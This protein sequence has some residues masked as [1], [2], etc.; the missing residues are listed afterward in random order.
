M[1]LP[2]QLVLCTNPVFAH[3]TFLCFFLHM[4]NEAG[5]LIKKK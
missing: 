4:V 5:V 2:A 1:A 3:D